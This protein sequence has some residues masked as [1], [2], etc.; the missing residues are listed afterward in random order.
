MENDYHPKRLAASA[1]NNSTPQCDPTPAEPQRPLPKGAIV[2]GRIGGN[3]TVVSDNPGRGEIIVMRHDGDG[4]HI[5]WDWPVGGETVTLVSLPD[6]PSVDID[7]DDKP[8]PTH[9]RH[10]KNEEGDGSES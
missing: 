6:P 4:K 5:P 8:T 10:L 2:S 9:W 3:A 1:W 7:P